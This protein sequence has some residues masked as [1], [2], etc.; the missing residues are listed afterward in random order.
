MWRI[1]V[2]SLEKV[3]S[4]SLTL[5]NAQKDV[6]VIGKNYSADRKMCVTHG[7]CRLQL[8]ACWL[9]HFVTALCPDHSNCLKRE[10]KGR[11]V[12]HLFYSIFVRKLEK[13]RSPQDVQVGGGRGGEGD[14]RAGE[15]FWRGGSAAKKQKERRKKIGSREWLCMLGAMWKHETELVH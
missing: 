10:C 8:V 3:M 2:N 6:A 13:E 1:E 14:D 11:F 4:A 5:W 7:E 9:T 15:K 12:F